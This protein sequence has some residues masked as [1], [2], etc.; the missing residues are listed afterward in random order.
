MRRWHRKPPASWNE[1][2]LGH[3]FTLEYLHQG[4]A[5]Q[6]Q[7]FPLFHIAKLAAL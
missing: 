4:K 6:A 1:T 2:P 7:G 3:Y 5:P